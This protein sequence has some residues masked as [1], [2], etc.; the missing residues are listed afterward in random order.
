MKAFPAKRR[1]TANTVLL[2]SSAY[3]SPRHARRDRAAAFGLRAARA[4]RYRRKASRARAKNRASP[5]WS[6]TFAPTTCGRDLS[7]APLNALRQVARGRAAPRWLVISGNTDRAG[8]GDIKVGVSEPLPRKSVHHH[9]AAPLAARYRSAPIST[10]STAVYEAAPGARRR[11]FGISGLETYRVLLANDFHPNRTVQFWLRGRRA[12][13]LI[14]R[15]RRG[16][17]EPR[18]GFAP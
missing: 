14:A 6:T 1:V 18:H 7:R 12:G 9:P 16:L 5:P 2:D 3:P 8:R 13:L 15:D 10:A 17:L 4:I 11:R